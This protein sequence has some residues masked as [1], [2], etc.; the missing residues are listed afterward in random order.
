MSE[1]GRTV[2]EGAVGAASTEQAA[3]T[4]AEMAA[5]LQRLLSGFTFQTGRAGRSVPGSAASPVDAP[6]TSA[7]PFDWSAPTPESVDLATTSH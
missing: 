3:S 1:I 4:L 5:E 6:A 2:E 7:V